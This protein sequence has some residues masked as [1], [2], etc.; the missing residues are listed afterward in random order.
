MMPRRRRQD[1]FIYAD[2]SAARLLRAT[3]FSLRRHAMLGL[4]RHAAA[5]ALM[6][7]A[8]SVLLVHLITERCCL[9]IHVTCRVATYV[10]VAELCRP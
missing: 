2:T 8:V 10:N 1:I 3:C 6:F 4:M 7:H 9:F 5:I